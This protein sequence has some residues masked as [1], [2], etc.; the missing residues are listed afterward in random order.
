MPV[1]HGT[2]YSHTLLQTNQCRASLL[3]EFGVRIEPTTPEGV[4]AEK[5][6]FDLTIMKNTPVHDLH[7]PL[8]PLWPESYL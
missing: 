8:I 6:T 1:H 4:F 7:C 5:W 3:L 2:N